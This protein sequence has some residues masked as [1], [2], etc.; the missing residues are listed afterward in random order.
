[1]TK[2]LKEEMIWIRLSR[3]QIFIKHKVPWSKFKLKNIKKHYKIWRN[4]LKA[5]SHKK[6]ENNK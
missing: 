3:K 2:Q 4:K 1:M 5:I 6:L